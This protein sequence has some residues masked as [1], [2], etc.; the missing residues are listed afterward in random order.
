METRSR[1]PAGYGGTRSGRAASGVAWRGGP[2]EVRSGEGS[3]ELPKDFIEKPELP[4][5]GKD[6]PPHDPS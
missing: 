4:P 1:A 3:G 2:Q 5:S 6:T